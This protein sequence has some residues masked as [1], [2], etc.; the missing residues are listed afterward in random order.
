MSRHLHGD[1]KTA[2]RDQLIRQMLEL[3]GYKILV[4]QAFSVQNGN[5]CIPHDGRRRPSYTLAV[6]SV[7]PLVFAVPSRRIDTVRS[8]RNTWAGGPA[9]E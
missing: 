6:N 7:Q 8:R 9:N 1:E 3:D 2:Q 4:V 5:S